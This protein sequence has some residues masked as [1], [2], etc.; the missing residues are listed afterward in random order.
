MT[1]QDTHELELRL[2]R[3]RPTPAPT[4]RGDL[5]RLLAGKVGHRSASRRARVLVVAYGLCGALLFAVGIASVG[6]VG[7]LAA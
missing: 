1:D 6:G 5:R 2:S 4:F 7:P 3:S